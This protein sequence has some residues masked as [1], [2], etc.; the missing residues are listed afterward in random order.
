MGEDHQGTEPGAVGGR[1]D[2]Q[3]REREASEV[4]ESKQDELSLGDE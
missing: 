3:R 1:R 2:Q 4:K